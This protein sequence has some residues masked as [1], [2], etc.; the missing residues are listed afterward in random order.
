R[1]LAREQQL[2][3]S[4][5]GRRESRRRNRI[6]HDNSMLQ[7]YP[8]PDAGS[9]LSAWADAMVASNGGR[10]EGERVAPWATSCRGRRRGVTVER[11]SGHN[12]EHLADR[13]AGR[14]Q[15]RR[16]LESRPS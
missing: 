8:S 12:T 10:R 11:R 9:K 14:L 7:N 15:D 6:G 4:V 1:L 5:G 16:E 13:S 3:V 2:A